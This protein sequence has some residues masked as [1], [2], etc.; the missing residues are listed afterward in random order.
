MTTEWRV[1]LVTGAAQGIGRRTAEVLAARGYAL[2][3]N[4]L[5][6][7]SRTAEVAGSFGAPVMEMPAMSPISRLLETWWRASSASLG[8]WMYW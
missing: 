3:L 2:V 6:T 8:A 1:A 5:Q 4:D 7:M